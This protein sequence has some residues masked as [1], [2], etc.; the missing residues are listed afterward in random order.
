MIEQVEFDDD[1]YC[2]TT[3]PIR[4]IFDYGESYSS[5]E[6]TDSSSS[7]E[8]EELI[9]TPLLVQLAREPTPSFRPYIKI[10][11]SPT[12]ES[13]VALTALIDTGTVCSTIRESH[14]ASEEDF[15]S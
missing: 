15:Y 10:V 2:W 7:E 13:Q 12:E 4:A 9:L 11:L 8:E 1:D 5:T 14:V 6:E 3:N